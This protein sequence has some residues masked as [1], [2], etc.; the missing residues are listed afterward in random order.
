MR[1]SQIIIEMIVIE[2]LVT[3]NGEEITMITRIKG[4][5]DLAQILIDLITQEIIMSLINSHI[6]II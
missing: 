3:S 2:P 1:L 6:K 5:L 4:H